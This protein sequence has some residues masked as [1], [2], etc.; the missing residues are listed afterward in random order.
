MQWVTAYSK[1]DPNMKYTI[2]RKCV[3]LQNIFASQWPSIKKK[4]S[5]KLVDDVCPF[6][7]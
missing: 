1:L 5:K 6:V 2:L 7:S 3:G 4:Q